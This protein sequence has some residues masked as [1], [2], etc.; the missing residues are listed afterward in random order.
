MVGVSVCVC[1]CGVGGAV[2]GGC[3]SMCMS[4]WGR[5]GCG[6]WVCRCIC[7][8]GEVCVCAVGVNVL[9]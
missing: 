1:L 7:L 9:V 4:V 6:W 2:G 8:C 5:W 3:V